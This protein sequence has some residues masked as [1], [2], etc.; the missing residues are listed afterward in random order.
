[1][2]YPRSMQGVR[3][4]LFHAALVV[5]LASVGCASDATAWEG[6]FPH[7]AVAADHVIASEAGAE[8]LRRGGNAVDAAVATSFTLSVVRPESCGLGGGG[9]MVI[10][11][12]R[13]PHRAEPVD[14]AI[15]YRETAPAAIGPDYYEALEDT[16]STHGGKAIG[17]PGTVAGLLHALDTFGTLDRSTVMAPA[18]RAAERG[19][20]A[21]K[22]YITEARDAIGN[23]EKHPEFKTR[24]AFVWSRYL[25]QGR[26]EEGNWIRVP[27]QAA[28]LRLIAEQGS[29]AFYEGPIA[30]AIVQAVQR[31]GGAMTRDDLRGYRVSQV[32]P[33]RF[34]FMD[35]TFL[36]MPPPSSGG[37]AMAEA[38][39]IF[40][41]IKP[42]PDLSV[43]PAEPARPRESLSEAIGR[44]LRPY[45]EYLFK[46][47]IY[48]RS[49]TYN[50][51]LAESFKHAFAD[52]ARWLGDPAFVNVPV[53]RLI[54]AEYASERAATFRADHT[55]PPEAY[56][57]PD[58]D[59][60]RG[61]APD[62]HGTSHLC[63][64]DQW[65]SAVSCTETVNLGFGSCL[66]VER[67][68]ILLNDQMDDFTT[69][70][71]KANAFGLRQSDRNLPAPGKRPLSSMTPTIVL[72]S[73]GQMEIICGASGGPRII[74][75]AVQTILNVLLFGESA[76]QAVFAPR[77]HHQWSPDTL[78]LEP[79]LF[80]N[81][82]CVRYDAF[83]PA[84]PSDQELRRLGYGTP[85]AGEGDAWVSILD[86]L[87]AY[88]HTVERIKTVADVQIITR[89]QVGRGWDAACDPRK[90]G[91][92]AGH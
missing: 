52:R 29:A 13:S 6:R 77:I 42:Q 47:S 39:G 69:R 23:F 59:E 8:I 72:N 49:P 62:D 48:R 10:H 41:R 25:R 92:P 22:H 14:V 7:G 1:M 35:L 17:I 3:W 36:T 60:Q 81:P 46:V 82:T 21:D 79:S 38:L 50:H 55:L 90:G 5:L 86:T 66:A 65:G 51:A 53:A 18:I 28:A 27:E 89:D 34:T 4:L 71:G 15:N 75:A 57:T 43:P 9:F 78:R 19:F 70:R 76:G 24:F 33:L 40:E 45:A 16:A 87:R 32:E 68:G 74:T 63:V 61:A 2:W 85:Q 20:R 54:S 11:L 26:V 64:V 73:E 58:P 44:C 80:D 91:R 67:Y 83:G 30:E 12:G 31:D 84:N 88:G 56:G 37:V